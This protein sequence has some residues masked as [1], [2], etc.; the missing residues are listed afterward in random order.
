MPTIDMSDLEERRIAV[1]R[2]YIWSAPR[3][4][5]IAALRD[6]KAGTI[7]APSFIPRE[8]EQLAREH[9]VEAAQVG[10]LAQGSGPA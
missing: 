3:G 1:Q 4:A 7:P 5:I 6:I 8:F 9:G 10:G 2:G